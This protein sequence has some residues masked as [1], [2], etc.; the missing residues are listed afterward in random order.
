M[1]WIYNSEPLQEIPNKAIGFVYQIHNT[2]TNKFYIGKKLFKHKRNKKTIES[3]W[4]SY[5][6]S[7][8]ILNEEIKTQNPILKKLILQICYSKSQCNYMEAFFQFKYNVLL[9]DQF[10][11]DWMSM[12]VTKKQLQKL[13]KLMLDEIDL[14]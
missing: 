10:Y 14:L 1:T 3:D 5:T 2:Q 12:K 11:N 8:K 7:N 4:K 6:G 9:S 13:S